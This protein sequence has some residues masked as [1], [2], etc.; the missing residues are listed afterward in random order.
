MCVRFEGLAVGWGVVKREGERVG[1]EV[2]YV[3]VVM[4]VSAT[5]T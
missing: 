4:C 2:C 3:E 1:I 5:R